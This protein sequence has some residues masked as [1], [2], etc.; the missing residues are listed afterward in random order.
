MKKPI[1]LAIVGCGDHARRSHVAPALRGRDFVITALCD[2]TEEQTQP[3]ADSIMA[4]THADKPPVF[5]GSA[6]RLLTDGGDSFDAVVDASPDG[7]H[8]NHLAMFVECGKHVMVE[9]PLGVKSDDFGLLRDLLAEAQRK[10]LIVTS[11]HPRRFD[12]PYL[13]L[14]ARLPML[15]KTF[16]R[17]LALEMDFSYHEPDPAKEGLHRG[18]LIDHFS[19]EADYAHFLLGRCPATFHRLSDALDRYRAVGIRDDGVALTFQ[20]SR[21]LGEKVY[22]EQVRMRFARGEAILHCKAG[23]LSMFHHGTGR[24]LNITVPATD[25]DRRFDGVMANFAAAIRGEAANY[26]TPADLI[27]NAEGGVR[28]TDD[29]SWTYLPR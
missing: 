2:L 6:Q 20:G 15:V 24:R 16:G 22:G 11:C 23:T 4:A 21:M 13:E 14:R 18:L 7:F 29:G 12:P 28:L 3:M 8:L 5:W 17:L 10:Q 26:L 27:A 19:H 1:R 9:K 25:Y